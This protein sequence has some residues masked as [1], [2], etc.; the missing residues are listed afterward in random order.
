MRSA[1]PVSA[2]SA[3]VISDDSEPTVDSRLN[4]APATSQSGAVPAD[5]GV[6][7]VVGDAPSE[8]DPPDPPLVHAA[9]PRP[10]TKQQRDRCAGERHGARP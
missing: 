7:V 1:Q 4:V 10:S 2:T 5:R 6:L 8:L 9:S 3:E